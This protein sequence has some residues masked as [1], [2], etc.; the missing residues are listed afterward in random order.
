MKGFGKVRGKKKRKVGR[1]VMGRQREENMAKF[2][3]EIL[4]KWVNFIGFEA[5]RKGDFLRKIQNGSV[6]TYLLL[7]LFGVGIILMIT[8]L[9]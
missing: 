1:K 6:E 3:R 5:K 8:F 4:D 7:M 2:D 9:I